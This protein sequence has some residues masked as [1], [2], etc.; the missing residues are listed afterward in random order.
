M[1][2]SGSY[3]AVYAIHM[4][5]GYLYYGLLWVVRLMWEMSQLRAV[6]L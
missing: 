6:L 3:I 2:P 5:R 4:G 1:C